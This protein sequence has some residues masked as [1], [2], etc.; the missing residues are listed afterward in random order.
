VREIK[1]RAWGYNPLIKKNYMFFGGIGCITIQEA[2]FNYNPELKE[3][4]IKNFIWMQYT[5]LKDKSGIEI[6]EGDILK[7]SG[8]YLN[9][10]IVEY[11][12]RGFELC[13]DKDGMVGEDTNWGYFEVI[14]NIYQDKKLLK[15]L[16]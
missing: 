5:G 3:K 13:D 6:Y 14:G 7:T 4:D 2:F 16:K 15:E 8:L 12:G 11:V 9:N 1:F 10:F